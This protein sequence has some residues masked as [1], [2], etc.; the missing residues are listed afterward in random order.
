MYEGVIDSKL[1]INYNGNVLD[2]SIRLVLTVP[3]VLFFTQKCKSVI[4]IKRELF[5]AV[6][7]IFSWIF[8]LVMFCLL[9]FCCCWSAGWFY[10]RIIDHYE[11]KIGWDE[12][13]RL[14]LSLQT[15]IFSRT[16]QYIMKSSLH[17]DESNQ[18]QKLSQ[19]TIH[20]MS[21]KLRT[22]VLSLTP[23]ALWWHEA[24]G[25]SP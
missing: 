16:L 23:K 9:H 18:W 21:T 24:R 7:V 12:T 25:K 22:S 14:H 5:H 6:L 1:Q 19:S 20:N 4:L 11:L 17:R 13:Q 2:N 15:Y 3:V 8:I 10:Q